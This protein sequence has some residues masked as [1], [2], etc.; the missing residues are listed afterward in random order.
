MMKATTRPGASLLRHVV[1]LLALALTLVP[2]GI[3]AAPA[4]AAISADEAITAALGRP[5]GATLQGLGSRVSRMGPDGDANYDASRP[6]SAYNAAD[7]Q[8]LVVWYGDTNTGGLVDDEFEIWGQ[9]IDAAS[10][11][12]IGT[13]VRI[14]QMGPDG[15][16]TY[17]ATN[18]AIAYNA[19]DNQ[20][21][22]VWTGDTNT[23]ELIDNEF[24]IWGQRL[25]ATGVE[26]GGDFRISQ[27]ESDGNAAYSAFDPAIAY[28]AID[29]QYLVVWHGGPS[30]PIAPRFNE[31]EIWGQRISNNGS[32]IGSD[33][34]ISQM[35]PDGNADY[36]ALDPAI[37][38]NAAGNQYLVVWQ[39]NTQASGVSNRE[40]EI[41]G[42][43]LDNLGSEIGGDFRI[44][45]MGPDFSLLYDVFEPGIAW[46]GADNEFLVVWYG[47]TNIDGLLDNQYEVWGQRLSNTGTE[48]GGD[49][50]ISNLVINT[51]VFS[52]EAQDPAIVWNATDNQYLVAWTADTT[53]GELIANEQEIWGQRL[54]ASGVELGGDFRISQMGPDGNQRYEAFS[55]VIA[56]NAADNQ[57]LVVWSG[58]TNAGG[59]GDEE[60]EIQAQRVADMQISRLWPDG[61]ASI[62]A[63]FPAAVYNAVNNEY[64][65]VWQGHN[66]ASASEL[67]IWGQRVDAASGAPLGVAFRISST[68]N[69]GDVLA[70]ARDPSVAWNAADNQYLVVWYGDKHNGLADEEYEIWGQRLNAT[71]SELGGDFRVSQMGPDGNA[72]YD[73]VNPI[74]T[75]NATSNQYL[76]V[77]QGNTNAPGLAAAEVEIWGKLLSNT[78]ANLSFDFRI[79]Q[80]G[81]DG[82][83]AYGAASPGLAWNATDNEYL[84]VWWGDTDAGRLLDDENEIW[85]QRLSNTGVELGPDFRISVTGPDRNLNFNAF[86]PEAVWNAAENEYL[87]VWWATT[88]IGGLGDH[89]YEIWG[90]RISAVGERRDGDFRIS[91]MGPDGDIRYD[92]LTPAVAWLPESNQYLVLWH[93]DTDAGGLVDDESEIWGRRLGPAGAAFEAQFRVSASGPADGSPAYGASNVGVVVGADGTALV[94]WQ[95][96]SALGGLVDDELEIWGRVLRQQQQQ[97]SIYLPLVRR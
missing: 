94:V 97:S 78:A 47:D 24:E 17:A 77:W 8:Y 71:G 22:I 90:G 41:W 75:Y 29:N 88:N 72:A 68:G 14:S 91:Q 48:L 58:D 38:Y 5:A 73:A 93:G 92:A 49:F 35:G 82:N 55:P 80:M 44:S 2:L 56:Y 1:G 16:A 6:A 86:Q 52:F 95:A 67:E 85:G 36:D 70:E 64:L 87:V 34:R 66:F 28:N 20:Y 26:L 32:E 76:V 69:A 50:R 51:T 74:V 81:P 83:A 31:L 25:S 15:N 23:G 61:I 33:F 96:D 57:Y 37:A 43:R 45:N 65:V 59:L 3:T 11:L 46:N 62:D 60:F 79:S 27:I 39:G 7:N 10:G 54:S 12:P 30:D 19:A 9:R 13:N 42:Q 21:L 40:K 89:E 18:P 84:V 63:S 4:T 53:V